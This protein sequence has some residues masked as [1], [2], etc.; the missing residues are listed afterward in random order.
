MFERLVVLE[1]LESSWPTASSHFSTHCSMSARRSVRV[2]VRVC[3]Q[4]RK[5]LASSRSMATTLLKSESRSSQGTP[6]STTSSSHCFE[7]PS[8]T[9]VVTSQVNMALQLCGRVFYRP[10]PVVWFA[11]R[12]DRPTR[13]C[14]CVRQTPTVPTQ[15]TLSTKTSSAAL[16]S[17]AMVLH[18]PTHLFVFPEV[19][20]FA[21]HVFLSRK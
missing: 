20:S 11:K 19:P 3:S 7:H 21:L 18:Q 8:K 10:L 4:P 16:T 12:H 1:L 5:P 14:R 17:R 9:F 13:Q 2:L 6:P 15:T